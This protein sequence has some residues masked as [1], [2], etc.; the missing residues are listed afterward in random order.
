METGT[1]AA[2]Y[3]IPGLLDVIDQELRIA[4]APPVPGAPERAV[5]RAEF[6]PDRG[7]P[8]VFKRIAPKGQS[9]FIRIERFELPA[10]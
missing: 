9:R 3:T 6:D 7:Y 10:K 2:Y 8:T 1:S 5:L 4:A